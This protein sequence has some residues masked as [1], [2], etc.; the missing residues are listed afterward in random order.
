MEVEVGIAAALVKEEEVA[1]AAVE[2]VAVAVAAATVLAV[3]VVAGPEVLFVEDK[4]G[5]A[6]LA[7]LGPQ[8]NGAPTTGTGTRGTDERMLTV[9]GAASGEIEESGVL[10]PCSVS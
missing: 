5:A 6:D 10:L 8:A 4:V 3:P 7:A 2:A 1:A 9:Q